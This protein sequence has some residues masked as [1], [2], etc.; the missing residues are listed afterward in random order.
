MN[1][2][3]KSLLN[4]GGKYRGLEILNDGE[5]PVLDISNE[6]FMSFFQVL[7]NNKKNDAMEELYSLHCDQ[8]SKN[9]INQLFGELAG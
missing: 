1:S 4:F 5:K 9:K 8:V 2:F 6:N 3:V 7:N